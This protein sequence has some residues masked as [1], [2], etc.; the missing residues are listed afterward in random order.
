MQTNSTTNEEGISEIP[1]TNLA[2]YNHR[3]TV[4]IDDK[5]IPGF[6][7]KYYKKDVGPHEVTMGVYRDASGAFASTS[8]IW[9]LSVRC[10]T[11]ATTAA[12]DSAAPLWR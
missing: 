1:P 4:T 9:P 12:K 5:V 10:R 11:S 2:E 8:G 6:T 7:A 3:D